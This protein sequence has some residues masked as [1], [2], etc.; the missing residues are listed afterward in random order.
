MYLSLVSSMKLYRTATYDNA[1]S[2]CAL[3]LKSVFC[4]YVF[5]L[6]L[7]W[8]LNFPAS[9]F[10]FFLL[11]SRSHFAPLDRFVRAS[12]SRNLSFSSP[13]RIYL[14]SFREIS[15]SMKRTTTA[16]TYKRIKVYQSYPAFHSRRYPEILKHAEAIDWS[17]IVLWKQTFFLSFCYSFL[18]SKRSSE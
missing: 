18:L 13:F 14:I 17:F 8:K 4:L 2:R 9:F 5:Y 7:T 16:I 15:R 1:S 3:V 10:F 12:V 6:F 11:L